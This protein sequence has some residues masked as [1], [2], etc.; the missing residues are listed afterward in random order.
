MKNSELS[1]EIGSSKHDWQIDTYAL[2]M[3]PITL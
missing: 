2:H 1:Y 3:H